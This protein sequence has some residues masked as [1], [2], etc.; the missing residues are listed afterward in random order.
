MKHAEKTRILVNKLPGGFFIFYTYKT[1]KHKLVQ[2]LVY[3]IISCAG[4]EENLMSKT[5]DWEKEKEISFMYEKVPSI[6]CKPSN[7]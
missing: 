7:F 1:C 6:D 3:D 4:L 5:K 2:Y